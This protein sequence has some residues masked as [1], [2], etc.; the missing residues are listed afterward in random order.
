MIH[1]YF[2]LCTESWRDMSKKE[3]VKN[4]I[5]TSGGIIKTAELINAGITK[6]DIAELYSN[7]Y[8]DKVKHGY[9]KLAKSN[10]SEEQILSTLLTD[11]IVCVQ[12]ALFHYGYSDF[13]PREWSIAVP[14]TVSRSKLKIEDIPIKAFYI[15][16]ELFELG[17]TTD[18]FNGFTLNIYDRE[19]T[20]CDCFKYKN[21][22]NSEIFN[23]AI[24][25][26]IADDNK[27]LANL[28]KY[29]KELKVYKKVTELMD[30]L[31][32]GSQSLICSRKVKEQSKR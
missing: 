29:A 30:V 15:K 9:Y 11:G 26:Y 7:F 18:D 31:L 24:N 8:I 12:S 13:A 10:I 2:I 23:K 5:E 1:N 16:E 6:T 4:A 3:I 25:V 22:L 28:S 32:N 14:R 19:R 20:L 17:K 27:N 21:Q